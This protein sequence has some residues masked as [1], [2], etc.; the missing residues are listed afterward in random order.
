MKLTSLLFLSFLMILSCGPS[1][2]ALYK[3]ALP[4][5][6]EARNK[7]YDAKISGDK[8]RSSCLRRC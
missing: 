1:G 7:A 6:L 8:D 2:K 4:E 3:G 5:E